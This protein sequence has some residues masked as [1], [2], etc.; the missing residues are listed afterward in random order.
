M[1]RRMFGDNMDIEFLNQLP[2]PRAVTQDVEGEAKGK[3]EV[4]EDWQKVG[5]GPIFLSIAMLMVKL[6]QFLT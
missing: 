2:A 1:R 6:T 4:G 3:L 5:V